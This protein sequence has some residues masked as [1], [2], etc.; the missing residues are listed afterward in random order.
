[1]MLNTCMVGDQLNSLHET[2][3]AQLQNASQVMVIGAAGMLGLAL[4]HVLVGRGYRVL[5]VTRQRFDALK[6]HVNTLPVQGL[7]AVI[8]AAGLINRRQAEEPA[9]A[10]WRVNALFPRQLAD[11]CEQS[12]TPLIHISTDCVFSGNGA[13]HDERATTDAQDLYGASKAAGEPRNARV[14]RTSIIGPEAV[15]STSLL[16]WFL[17]QRGEVPGFTNHLWNGVTTLELARVLAC[18]LDEGFD[19]ERGL[20]H[21]Y[22]E[23]ITKHD[24]LVRMAHVF[25][26]PVQVRPVADGPV[27]D[28]RLKTHYPQELERWQVQSLWDQLYAMRPICDRGGVWRSVEHLTE[29]G[30]WTR[31]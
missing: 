21:I 20:R 7:R 1:M 26:H 11:H 24:L 22:G 9:E 8:N 14:I 12:G 30:G 27:R 6:D 10:F 15:R 31:S 3:Y 19:R 2:A 23:D 25:E 17:R 16:C 5:P 29:Q 13:P 18:M 4:C 28:M